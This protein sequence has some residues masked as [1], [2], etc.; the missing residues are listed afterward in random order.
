MNAEALI[1]V[2]T[3][4]EDLKDVGKKLTEVGVNFNCDK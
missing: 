3:F 2:I 4:I 1:T